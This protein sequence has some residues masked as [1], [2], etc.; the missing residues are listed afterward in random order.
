MECQRTQI[1]YAQAMTML[2]T[3]SNDSGS[4]HYTRLRLL[5]QEAKMRRDAAYMARVQHQD[6]H[7]CAAGTFWDHDS[8]ASVNPAWSQTAARPRTVSV[9]VA[10][11][12]NRS[13]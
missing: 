2:S 12:S 4:E 10:D 13:N 11:S 9:E 5:A 7:A 8:M 6:R 3:A 1:I